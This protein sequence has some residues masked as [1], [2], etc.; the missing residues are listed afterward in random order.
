MPTGTFQRGNARRLPETRSIGAGE[1]WRVRAQL[2][3]R[4]YGREKL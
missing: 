2:E 3:P 1:V 4:M